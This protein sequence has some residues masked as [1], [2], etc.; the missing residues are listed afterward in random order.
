M[1]VYKLRK[2]QGDGE[3]N[4]LIFAE[5]PRSP[6]YVFA[7]VPETVTLKLDFLDKR[8]MCHLIES[9]NVSAIYV[10]Q[11]LPLM[12]RL[13]RICYTCADHQVRSMHVGSLCGTP[14]QF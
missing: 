4:H 5:D 3:E 12:D 1:S 9:C 11:E 6:G 13:R 14:G 10:L 8:C 7:H 2:L